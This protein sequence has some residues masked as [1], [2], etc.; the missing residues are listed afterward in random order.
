VLQI[1]SQEDKLVNSVTASDS[2]D[3]FC[4]GWAW[5]SGGVYFQEVFTPHDVA[6]IGPQP[7]HGPL[8]LLKAE[9]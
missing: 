7:W 2:A 8:E 1:Y 5:D 4:H 6:V 9:P 3:L